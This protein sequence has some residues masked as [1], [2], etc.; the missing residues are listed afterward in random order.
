[1]VSCEIFEALKSS[2]VD[3]VAAVVWAGPQQLAAYKL[4]KAALDVIALS[5]VRLADAAR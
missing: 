1:M 3:D 5:R 2:E 4:T